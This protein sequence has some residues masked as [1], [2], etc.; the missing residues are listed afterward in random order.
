MNRGGL[1]YANA[2]L[3]DDFGYNICIFLLLFLLLIF[4]LFLLLFL[5]I[6]IRTRFDSDFKFGPLLL[7]LRCGTCVSTGGE[8]GFSHGDR[9]EVN[10]KVW[11]D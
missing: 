1:F 11:T 4:I 7:L 9:F 2:K 5:L 10:P 6:P 8:H 3:L